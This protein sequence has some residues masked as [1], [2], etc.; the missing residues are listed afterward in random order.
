MEIEFLRKKA[1][2]FRRLAKECSPQIATEVAAVASELDKM[3]NELETLRD[4]KEQ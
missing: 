2:H 1:E 4:Q 3:A